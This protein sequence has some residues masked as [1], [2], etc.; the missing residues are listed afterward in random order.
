MK[1][2]GEFKRLESVV[3]FIET[4]GRMF[5]NYHLSRLPNL[6][7]LDEQI[8]TNV[9]LCDMQYMSECKLK[10]HNTTIRLDKSSDKFGR[11]KWLAK[12]LAVVD[13]NFY[14]EWCTGS[15]HVV[16]IMGSWSD[17]FEYNEVD[18][19]E[20][21]YEKRL[22]ESYGQRYANYTVSIGEDES[23]RFY[24]KVEGYFHGIK[25]EE[26]EILRK[27]AEEMSKKLKEQEEFEKK[28]SL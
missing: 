18:E 25:E 24:P 2:I 20:S 4:L 13:G 10:I 16:R 15:D 23:E 6:I 26:D 3:S 17:S 14:F 27:E 22:I 5:N 8:D 7:Y 21:R 9:T 1:F 19:A 11:D 12:T 28:Y